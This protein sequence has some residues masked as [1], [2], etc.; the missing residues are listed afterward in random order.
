MRR[1][2]LAAITTTGTEQLPCDDK[3]LRIQSPC[4]RDSV[5]TKRAA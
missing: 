4:Q 3:A 5:A 2:R 1:L